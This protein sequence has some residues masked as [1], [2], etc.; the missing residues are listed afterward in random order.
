M[1]RGLIRRVVVAFVPVVLGVAVAAAAGSGHGARSGLERDA[2]PLAP[3][4]TRAGST[5]APQPPRIGPMAEIGH[6]TSPPLRDIP[7]K[8]PSTVRKV[9]VEHPIPVP[10]GSGTADPVVQTTA[11]AAAAPT[12]TANFE[13]IPV[14]DSAP[15]D[16]NAAAGPS[17][18]V[19]IVNEEFAVYS[20]TGSLIYGPAATN[21]LW[22]GFGG[23]CDSNDDGDATVVYDRLANRWVIQQ[24]SVSTSPY[25]ECIAVSAT[26]DPTGS[27]HRYAFGGFGSNFPDYPKLGVWPDAYYVTYN[28]FPDAGGYDGPEVCAYERAQMLAGLSARQFCKLTGNTNLGGLL[29]AD[30]DGPTAPP[31]GSPEFLTAF[32]T[33]VLDLW[34]L[35]VT[36][37]S[38]PSGSL[39]GPTSLPVAA[40][41]PACG[42]GGTCIP[43]KPGD[44]T[45]LDSLGDR[46]MY[47]LAY[48]NFGDHESMV[49]TQTVQA[50]SST[51]I[52]WYEIRDPNGTP[53]VYQ[54][55]TYAPDSTYRWMGS[56]AMDGSGDIALGYSD[57]SSSAHPSIRYTGRLA[58]D[59]LGTMT[60]GEGTLITGGGSQNNGLYRWGDYSSMSVDPSDDCTFWYTNEYIPSD[61]NFN[62]HT[63]IGSFKL[64]SSCSA[65]ATNDFSL[66]ASPTSVSVEQGS[67]GSTTVSAAVTAGSAQSV[68]LSASGLPF[69]ATAS[70][71]PSPI[72]AGDSSTMTIDVGA[73]TPVG[74]YP[75]TVTGSGAS[76]AQ[77]T[78]VT[79]TVTLLNAVTNGGFEAGLTGWTAGGGFPPVIVSG[80]AKKKQVHAGTQAVQLGSTSRFA[81]DS[82]LSQT[83]TVQA[84]ATQLSF[85]YSPRCRGTI[86]T[87]H[88]QAQIRATDGSTLAT[89]LDV[90]SRT[91]SWR[92]VTFDTS[93]FA[94]Q[95]VVL[96]FNAH[97][98]GLKTNSFL[99]DDVAVTRGTGAVVQNG[100]FETGGGLASW[101][102]GGVQAPAIVSTAHGGTAALELG[103]STP[104]DGDSS[105][106]QTVIVPGGSPTLTF[107]YQPHCSDTIDYDQIQV[108]IRTTLGQVLSSALN[109]C[110]QSSTW[111]KGTMSLSAYAG[112]Q[113]V[114]YLNVHDDG[115][116]QDPTYAL[117]DDV[118]IG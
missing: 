29:P 79:L 39:T 60:Q 55:G 16:P 58:G 11:P 108:Q 30:L 42:D 89:V 34:K 59:S 15:P 65:T 105:V 43:Q 17:S 113:V 72:T 102:A 22:T 31:S 51:G 90:C 19:E 41:T 6:D 110:S 56:A 73:D 84:G 32:D 33:G 117:F 66:T 47:R 24:F 48:R 100:G 71:S 70:F 96:W 91:K 3:T 38:T 92:Q 61:G 62:W 95:T 12:A 86:A 64:S 109:V 18:I 1:S 20:K 27:W 52:R 4:G 49:V 9:R 67:S 2:A 44:G 57:S 45:T 85:W 69:D 115:A 46:L 50:G 13:G 25:L 114:L 77:T 93:A 26:S 78:T 101:T 8:K 118:S 23:G 107:Y 116:P 103:S 106:Q 87:N 37:G 21:T 14:Q 54:Q 111:V 28:L 68:S 83:V 104:F 97:G 99:L 74:T 36:W 81:G 94:G 40:F 53:T 35:K 75:I 63:R 7:P 5:T 82:T 76:S 80:S 88:I 98:D 10:A 112:Q